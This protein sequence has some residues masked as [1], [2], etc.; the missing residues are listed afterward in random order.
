MRLVPLNRIEKD[1]N[2]NG[3]NIENGVLEQSYNK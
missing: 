2:K 1:L 3:K